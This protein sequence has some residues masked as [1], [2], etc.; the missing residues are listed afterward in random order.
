MPSACWG[1]HRSHT[2]TDLGSGLTGG[3]DS[4]GMSC[5]SI[6]RVP[7]V[8]A[9]SSKEGVSHF[10]IQTLFRRERQ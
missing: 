10:N 5:H 6:S 9:T 4:A 7:C 8:P 3:G 2:V 1:R